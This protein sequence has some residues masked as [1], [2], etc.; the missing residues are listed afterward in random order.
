M[1]TEI[2]EGKPFHIVSEK[3]PSKVLTLKGHG[4]S[5]FALED[6]SDSMSYKQ[7]FTYKH[8]DR[9]LCLQHHKDTVVALKQEQEGSALV[10]MKEGTER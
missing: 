6:P 1:E 7:E 3:H 10:R 5:D 9:N 4:R 2:R 8:S